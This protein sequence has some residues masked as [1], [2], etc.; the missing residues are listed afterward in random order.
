MKTLSSPALLLAV[1]LA[2]A[3]WHSSS[4]RVFAESGAIQV[5]ASVRNPLDQREDFPRFPT[6]EQQISMLR[7]ESLEASFHRLK[8]VN[9]FFWPGPPPDPGSY[10]LDPPGD[11]PLTDKEEQYSIH[12]IMSNRRVLKLYKELGAMPKDRAANL[13]NRALEDGL[14]EYLAA[15]AADA[16]IHDP[17]T[18]TK[19]EAE[20]AAVT[21]GRGYTGVGFTSNT[22]SHNE[23]TLAGLRYNVL[24]W[25]W[26]AGVLELDGVRQM[27]INVAQEARQQ[28]EVLFIDRIHHSLYKET[29]LKNLSL[30]NRTILFSALMRTCEGLEE[31]AKGGVFGTLERMEARQTA[32]DAAYTCYDRERR[33]DFSKGEIVIEYWAGVT[34]AMFDR[35]L[36]AAAAEK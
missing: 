1:A 28:R 7:D 24:S 29:I 31:Q 36:A 9:M 18:H 19:E 11:R 6:P 14:A 35:A 10:S 12:V 8:N 21:S 27:L 13:V 25:A 22:L 20:L 34:D 17:N 2:D 15:Y 4:A 30:Y 16:V 33:P 26:L 32:F 5:A 23:V 3:F